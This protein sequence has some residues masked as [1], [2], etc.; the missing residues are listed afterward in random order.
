MKKQMPHDGFPDVGI[1]TLKF[2]AFSIVARLTVHLIMPISTVSL[3]S[4]DGNH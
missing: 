2:E 3:C 4:G 1:R